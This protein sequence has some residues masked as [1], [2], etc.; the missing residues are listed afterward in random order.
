MKKKIAVLILA[1]S[2]SEA[3]TR[4]ITLLSQ[5]F[6]I[7]VQIDK[8]SKLNID[9]LPKITNCFYF[10]EITVFWG[11]YSQIENMC[12]ILREAFNPKYSHYVFISGED[13]PIKSNS[14]ISSFFNENIKNSYMS[15]RKFP[16]S[17]LGFNGGLDR[18]QRYWFMKINN[19]L[20]AKIVARLTLF[21]QKLFHIKVKTFK[22]DFYGGSNW[23]NISHEAL[24]YV[25]NF[26][27]ENPSYMKKLKYSRATDEVWIQSILMNSPLRDNIILDDLRYTDW[28]SGPEYPKT[29][30]IQ[31]YQKIIESNALFARKVKK[32]ND[33]VLIEK[34]FKK[35]KNE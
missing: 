21:V 1:H 22:I 18:V 25:F 29:L 17:S 8:K 20:I 33:N 32:E 23:I 4:T 5:N 11:G 27:N 12:F 34:I 19:R 2:N 31:D 24:Q 9:D 13:I 35:I 30:T 10:K 26:L 3:L 14:Y 7:F 16:V 28:E 6:D 15:A